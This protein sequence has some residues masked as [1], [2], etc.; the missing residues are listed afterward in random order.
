[1]TVKKMRHVPLIETIEDAFTQ[2]SGHHPTGK[3]ATKSKNTEK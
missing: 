1:M 3:A 2:Q